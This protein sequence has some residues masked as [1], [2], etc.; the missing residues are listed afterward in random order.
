MAH[1]SKNAEIVQ[2]EKQRQAMLKSKIILKV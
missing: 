2:Y 1:H